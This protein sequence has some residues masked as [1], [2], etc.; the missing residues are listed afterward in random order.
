VIRK[1]EVWGGL[2]WL[3][4]GAFVAWQGYEMGLG[5]LH[6]PGSG[7]AF[8]WIGVLMVAL[9]LVN[10]V[11]GIVSAGPDLAELWKN[12]RWGRILVVTAVLLVYGTLFETVGFIPLSLALL[13]L[14][15]FFIDP[16]KWWL[17]IPVSFIA[18]IG[19]WYVMSR[20]LKIQL[21]AGVLAPWLQ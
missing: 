2:F 5:Q 16:V 14:L 8:F 17:A 6:E 7:F 19:V 18:T 12:T 20:L 13:L 1:A 11:E 4:V 15:M 9:A 21:P 10:V 3:G